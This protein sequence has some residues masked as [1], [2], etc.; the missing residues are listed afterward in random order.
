MTNI[1]LSYRRGGTRADTGRIYDRLSAQFGEAS[2]FMDIDDIEPGE[3]FVHKLESTLAT[4]DVLLVIMGKDWVDMRSEDGKPRLGAEGDFVSMEIQQALARNINIIPVL[5]G[6]ASMPTAQQLPFELNVLSQYQAIEISDQRFHEDVDDLIDAI[7]R[8]SRSVVRQ[9]SRWKMMAAGFAIILLGFLLAFILATDEKYSLRSES[10]ILTV[11]QAK[12][13]LVDQDLFDIS[14]NAG[15]QG[16]ENR[17]TKQ[18]VGGDLVIVD[19]NTGLMWQKAGSA[20]AM[21]FA[22]AQDYIDSLNSRGF[23]DQTDWRL[24]TFEEAMSLMKN[25]K[26]GV[27]HIDPSFE[28][29][30][31]PF[32]FT[33]DQTPKQQSW[34]VYYYDGVVRPESAQFNASVRAV[35][36]IR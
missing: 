2:V 14:W 16:L 35:R 13:V 24:P 23:A 4:C 5:V 8:F 6:G 10:R 27:Y 9:V 32:I 19:N 15:G 33:S 22:L 30:A 17:L 25:I 29:N 26:F 28:S 36:T 34:V 21:T 3:N 11:E 7:E 31:A 12:V 1:F 20:R 18:A